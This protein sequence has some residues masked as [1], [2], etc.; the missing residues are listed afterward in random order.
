ML[1]AQVGDQVVQAAPDS[2][3]Q[4]RCPVCG[5]GVVKRKRRRMDGST[6]Y[7][8]RHSDGE[9]DDCPQRYTPIGVE[10]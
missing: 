5:G 4:A 3:E 7:F 8:Y 10:R 1:E 6:A 2:P 9:G